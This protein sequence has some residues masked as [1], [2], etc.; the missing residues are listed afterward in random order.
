MLKHQVLLIFLM[1][2][3]MIAQGSEAKTQDTTQLKNSMLKNSC[4][5]N[6]LMLTLTPET[7]KYAKTGILFGSKKP[8]HS[9]DVYMAALGMSSLLKSY[10]ES[11][12]Q[13]IGNPNLLSAAVYSGQKDVVSMLLEMGSDPNKLGKGASAP[14]LFQAAECARPKI[15]LYLIQAGADIY[16]TA[17]DGRSL[18]MAYALIGT[19]LDNRPFIKGVQLLLAAGFDP[20]CPVAKNGLTALDVVKRGLRYLRYDA[21]GEK[22]RR[23]LLKLLT[24]TTKI[25]ERRH[26]GRPS[27][28]G[29]D[30]WAD[31][32]GK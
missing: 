16:G 22:D 4:D 25:A 17:S 29:L 19:G 21:D 28:G 7:I 24:I 6:Y 23:K 12:P 20:R 15:M 27:C 3:L 14:P 18:A 10:L 1:G 9:R 31:T 13:Q 32:S 30:W 11:H 2:G 26:P 5:T 8:I